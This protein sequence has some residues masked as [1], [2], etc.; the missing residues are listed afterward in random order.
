[1]GETDKHKKEFIKPKLN[2]S[3][4]SL[5]EP[6]KCPRVM[7]DYESKGNWMEKNTNGYS[8]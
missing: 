3:S 4:T 6:L 1:M 8:K 7:G 2:M 5:K